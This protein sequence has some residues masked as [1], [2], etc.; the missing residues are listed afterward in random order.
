MLK[1]SAEVA[2][3]AGSADLNDVQRISN[4]PTNKCDRLIFSLQ[5]ALATLPREQ[6]RGEFGFR[7]S[8]SKKLPALILTSI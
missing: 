6:K 1:H 7:R 3:G 4:S 5:H 2:N 8:H